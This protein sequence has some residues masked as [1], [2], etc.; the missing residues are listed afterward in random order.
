MSMLLIKK[1]LWDSRN[2]FHIGKHYIAPE[3]VEEICYDQPIVQ[4]GK[5]RSRIVILGH[6]SNKRLLIVIL[7]NKGKG[8][9]YIVTAYDANPSDKALYQRLKGG[10]KK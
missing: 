9:Y 10:E 2:I 5:K 1:L 8:S 7:E 3:E 6:T 4:R